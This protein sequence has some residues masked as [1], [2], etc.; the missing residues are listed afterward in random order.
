MADPALTDTDTLPPPQVPLSGPGGWYYPDY[1]SAP[2]AAPEGSAAGRVLGAFREGANAAGPASGDLSPETIDRLKNL[3]GFESW[4][5][6]AQNLTR[7]VNEVLIRPSVYDLSLAWH[8]MTGALSG[9]QAAVAQTGQEIG[10]PRLGRDIAAIPEAF[11]TFDFRMGTPSVAVAEAQR[12]AELRPLEPGTITAAE[13]PVAGPPRSIDDQRAFIA[14]HLEDQLVRAGLPAQESR[15]IAALEAS[16]YTEWSRWFRGALGSPEEMYVRDAAEILGPGGRSQQPGHPP[17]GVVE[18]GVD[19]ERVTGMLERFEGYR[20]VITAFKT[21]DAATIMHEKGHEWLEQLLRYAEHPAAPD[22]FKATAAQARD[23]LGMAPDQA[24]PTLAQHEKFARGFEQ[25]L[26]EGKAPSPEMASIFER[27]RQ[28]LLAI[29][30]TIRDLGKPIDEN[31]RDVF[32][33]ML[34]Q[35]PQREPITGASEAESHGNWW[36]TDPNYVEPADAAAAIDRL[37]QEREKWLND[38]PENIRAELAAALGR[39]DQPQ[40]TPAP[41]P[42]VAKVET[43]APPPASQPTL[44]EM[45]RAIDQQRAGR[46]K[47]RVRPQQPPAAATLASG[48]ASAGKAWAGPAI[49]DELRRQQRSGRWQR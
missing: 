1:A 3:T 42:Q 25:Y 16:H 9:G 38:A 36:E 23:W 32:D 10:Q 27:F 44:R 15:D 41:P 20:P 24:Q 43:P 30:E 18:E 29:Y 34:A 13:P 17:T 6:P 8:A 47:L 37:H 7:A 49:V 19:P 11:P 35:E 46:P 12:A 21:D 33:R 4:P 48:G 26:R 14:G 39:L 31:I 40:P 45:F 28:H 2:T 22:D 5:R